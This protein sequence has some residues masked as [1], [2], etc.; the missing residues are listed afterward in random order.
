MKIITVTLN[1]C[2]DVNYK[3]SSSFRAGELNR[4]PKPETEICG[5]GINVSRA[6]RAAGKVS[7]VMGIF[8]G[9]ADME[10]LRAEGLTVSG[11]TAGG[12]LRRNTAI[13]DSDGVQ[14]QINEPGI[15]VTEEKLREFIGLYKS[16]L[17][18]GGDALVVLSGSIPP[19]VD[20]GIYRKLITI[21]KNSG[22]Y[23]ALDADGEALAAGLDAIPDLIKPNKEEFEALIGKKLSGHGEG[24]RLDAVREALEFARNNNCAV[25][26]TLGEDG[27]VYAGEGGSFM[28][29][30][31]KTEIKTFKGAG[32]TFL[33]VFL[34]EHVVNGKDCDIAMMLAST[35]TSRRLANGGFAAVT[36]IVK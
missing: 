22:A 2:V 5:K 13:L 30:A 3:L 29:E 25:L 11:V 9:D 19:G 17:N 31:T 23:T 6:V 33:A 26:C 27:S 36:T 35:A 32:D 12:S 4:V 10:A 20:T 21:A 34:T 14:T 1:P 18:C 28:C 15:T 16:E 8:A 7:T 24:L